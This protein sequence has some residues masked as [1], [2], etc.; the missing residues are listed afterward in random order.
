MA[1]DIKSESENLPNLEH[2]ATPKPRSERVSVIGT[3]SP[4]R[5]SRKSSIKIGTSQ[6]LAEIKKSELSFE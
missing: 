1:N 2:F 3:Q 6:W 4:Y 5:K